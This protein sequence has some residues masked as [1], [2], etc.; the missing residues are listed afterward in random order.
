MDSRIPTLPQRSIQPTDFL[1]SLGRMFHLGGWALVGTI[2]AAIV[3]AANVRYNKIVKATAIAR[4]AGELRVIQAPIAGTIAQILVQENQVVKA[5]D[6]I[7][8]LEHSQ[9]DTDRQSLQMHLHQTQLQLQQINNQIQ[10][11]KIQQQSEQFA[12]QRSVAVAAADLAKQERELHDRQLISQ[13]D[14]REAE[15]QVAF[16]R[17]AMQRYQALADTGAIALIQVKAKE[18]AFQTAIA[19]RDRAL[20][21]A[22]PGNDA[23]IAAEQTIEQQQV[24]G[25]VTVAKLAQEKNRLS[26]QRI[27]LQTQIDRDRTALQQLQKDQQKPILRSPIAGKLHQLNLRNVGQFIPLGQTIAQVAPPD[28]ALQFKAQIAA[29]DMGQIQRCLPVAIV[30]PDACNTVEM[31]FVAYP[32]AEYGTLPGKI[33]GI[34]P[35]VVTPG[36]YE[37]T[38]QP[39][40]LSLT[41]AGQAFPIA[42]SMSATVEITTQR[43]TFLGFLRRQVRLGGDR[44]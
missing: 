9:L 42:P 25:D 33:V 44:N 32:H 26:S 13:A 10:Q 22:N 18:E 29:E 39:D 34:T 5:G 21:Q 41:K 16:A 3:L 8:I 43:E 20:A 23:I 15:A 11:L 1:P 28:A 24:I 17:D 14:L 38:I 37:M 30:P 36:F 27:A 40:R 31:R 6:P 7:A 4:P 12:N 2:V 35:D 19:K